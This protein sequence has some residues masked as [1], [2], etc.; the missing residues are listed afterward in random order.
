MLTVDGSFGEGGGQIFRSS[1]SCA[2]LTGRP[3]QIENIR[4][5]RGKPGLLRQHLTAL[6][7]IKQ[8]C[9]AEVE[10]E[11]LGAMQVRITPGAVT[12]G[13]YHFAVGSAG[14]ANLVL[15]T[16]LPPLMLAS[17]PSTVVVEG[18]THN[19]SSPS[20]DFL[21]R[22]F[23]PRLRA[24]GVGLE[25]RL[26]RPGFYPAGGG[27]LEVD[28]VPPASGQL[29]GIELFE[30]GALVERRAEALLAHL[31]RTIGQRELSAF[32]RKVDWPADRLRVVR[33]DHA[34]GPGNAFIAEL[35]YE[36]VSEMVTTFG[37]KGVR[38]EQVGADCALGV[39]DYLAQEAP[40][41]EHLADQLILPLALGGGG[42]LTGRLSKHTETNVEVVKRLLEVEL[43]LSRDGARVVIRR[44]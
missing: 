4:A 28:I 3:V 7:A 20:F 41:G 44:G 18:G 25:V 1:L 33:A 2:A 12:P 36:H 24:M 32:S 16:V 43:E 8:I 11:E 30:R 10:G 21:D 34:R 5:G 40:V 14:S 13:H 27:Q 39:R 38:A 6:R 15:Q 42:F 19:P 29:S 23:F 31:P 9:G 37:S 26:V 22:V 35:V 17:G